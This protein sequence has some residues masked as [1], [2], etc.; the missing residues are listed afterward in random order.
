[1]ADRLAVTDDGKRAQA[2]A[3]GAL[4]DWLQDNGFKVGTDNLAAQ[5]NECKWYAWR[6]LPAGAR[7]CE[8]NDKPPSLIVTPHL[9]TMRDRQYTS[10]EVGITGQHAGTWFH[11]KAYSIGVDELP[12]QLPRI[13]S[14]LTSAW[15]A[16]AAADGAISPTPPAESKQGA[17]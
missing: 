12:S 9:F 6:S 7:D 13:E 8:C 16:L 5:E 15:I 11:L 1:M 4:C 17:A 10:V 14:A 2:E 3:V